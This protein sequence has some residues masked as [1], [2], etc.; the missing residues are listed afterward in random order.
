MRRRSELT[1]GRL[2]AN[3]VAYGVAIFLLVPTALVDFGLLPSV[4]FYYQGDDFLTPGNTLRLHGATWGKRW[5]NATMADRYALDA[6]RARAVAHGL[7]GNTMSV[8]PKKVEGKYRYVMDPQST[9]TKQDDMAA[10]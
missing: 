2:A 9:L 8:D 5:I 10:L 4:G 6:L 7:K 1:A 3:A